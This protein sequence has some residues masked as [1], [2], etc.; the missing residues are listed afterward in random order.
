M[1]HPN[2]YFWK[3][4]DG[5][6]HRADRFPNDVK[7]LGRMMP[8][9]PLQMGLDAAVPALTLDE[10]Q[11][12]LERAFGLLGMAY[13][14]LAHTL[15]LTTGHYPE[16]AMLP[17]GGF[18]RELL[19]PGLYLVIDGSPERRVL[20]LGSACDSTMRNR[21]ISHL[22]ADGRL[23]PAQQFLRKQLQCWQVFGFPDTEVADAELRRGVWGRNRWVD[24]RMLGVR[25]LAAELVSQGA[26]DVSAVRV[27]DDHAGLARCLE[28]FATEFVRAR[29]GQYPPL[30]EHPVQFDLK[31]GYA[32]A[33]LATLRMTFEALDALARHL[34][35]L[36]SSDAASSP[37]RLT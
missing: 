27:P 2:A 37:G 29:T 26:F 18:R 1:S 10:L 6:S 33:P 4:G 11:A 22:F 36:E 21:L 34:G 19:F 7:L 23:H 16:L 15:E 5:R 28:R 14:A 8:L 24:S 25:H 3:P 9:A 12:G 13:P 30:N 32:S 17:S 35:A 31:S 20:Y